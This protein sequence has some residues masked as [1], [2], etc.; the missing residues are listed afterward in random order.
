[1]A[2]IGGS[3]AAKMVI[4]S[5]TSRCGMIDTPRDREGLVKLI[6]KGL[7]VSS[8]FAPEVASLLAHRSTPKV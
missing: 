1:M 2:P 5:D 6:M 4:T 3:R 7:N 8:V